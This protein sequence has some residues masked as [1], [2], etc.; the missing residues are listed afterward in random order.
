M[1]GPATRSRVPAR[2]W[3][4]FPAPAPPRS[5]R[6]PPDRPPF[7]LRVV[8]KGRAHAAH[9]SLIEAAGPRSRLVANRGSFSVVV[10]SKG[11]VIAHSAAVTVRQVRMVLHS[12]TTSGMPFTSRTRSGTT[13]A[14]PLLKPGWQSTRYWLIT[15]KRLL[16]GVSQFDVRLAAPAVPAGQA[17]YRQPTD[18][19]GGG[20]L[21]G[22]AVRAQPGDRLIRRRIAAHHPARAC[23]Q[24]RGFSARSCSRS[25]HSV[26]LDRPVA[27]GSSSR[28]RYRP[29]R[30][31]ATGLRT[32]FRHHRVPSPSGALLLW[33][34]LGA[35]VCRGR[36]GR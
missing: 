6:N 20:L 26:K 11:D 10:H 34:R 35:V 13:K 17:F 5:Y 15:V 2:E 25:S 32:A 8:L 4:T 16:A 30:V 1:R 23:R 12:T 22:L 27:R 9:P 21:V 29:N 28:P 14:L 31:P 36:G 7:S 3:P 33:S 24:A 18:Q 19:E